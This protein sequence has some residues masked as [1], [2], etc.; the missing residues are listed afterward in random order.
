[1]ERY[2]SSLQNQNLVGLAASGKELAGLF[3]VQW[4]I[5]SHGRVVSKGVRQSDLFMLLHLTIP[6]EVVPNYLGLFGLL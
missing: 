2:R 5:G 6:R 1:M 4:D 3:Y